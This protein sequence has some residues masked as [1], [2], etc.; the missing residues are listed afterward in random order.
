MQ[1]F[2]WYSKA[3]KNYAFG[4]IVAIGTDVEEARTN[5]RAQFET[6]ARERWDWLFGKYADYK[7]D[8][9]DQEEHDAKLAQLEADIMEEPEIGLAFFVKGG[10]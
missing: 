8:E 9:D 5:A 4:H 1:V 6:V 10:E 2:R 3:L 7:L